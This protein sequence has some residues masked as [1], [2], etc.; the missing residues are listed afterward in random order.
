MRTCDA[1]NIPLVTFVDVPGFIPGTNQEHGGIIR[2]GAKLLYAYCESTVPR[3]QVITRKGYGGAYVVMDSKSIGSDIAYAWPTAEIAVMNSHG[4][5]NILLRRELAESDDPVARKAQWDEEYSERLREPVQRGRARLRRR[6]DRPARHPSPAH[7]RA[8][9]CCARRRS[10]CR[11]A[12]TGTCPCDAARRAPALRVIDAGASPEEVAAIVAAV[13]AALASGAT[14]AERRRSRRRVGSPRR[15]CARAGARARRVATGAGS[16]G[17]AAGSP[18]ERASGPPRSRPSAPTRSRSRSSPSPTSPS[19]PRSA[20]RRSRTTGPFHV[21]DGR[22]A[23]AR[24]RVHARGRRRR[25]RRARPRRGAHARG[26]GGSAP[27][28]DRD[29]QRRAL[30]RDRLR[31]DP[32]HDR[33]GARPVGAVRPG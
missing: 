4:A 21:V 31:D 12:S 29:G 9:R 19:R 10:A 24:H 26:A 25:A 27:R 5:A 32:H 18:R 8:R 23:R 20:T 30:R 14:A 3:I 16:D 13:T 2:H 22:R 1:F 11:R 15:G 6:R 7:R 17:S 28:D 33:G